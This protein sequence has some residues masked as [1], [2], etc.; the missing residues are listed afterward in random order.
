MHPLVIPDLTKHIRHA[1][2]GAVVLL[3]EA[4]ESLPLE[5]GVF[6]YEFHVFVLGMILQFG[7]QPVTARRFN[8][9]K[10]PADVV[11]DEGDYLGQDAIEKKIFFD[12]TV[13]GEF[14]QN[15]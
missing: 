2:K 6:R 5:L 3:K 7:V 1:L 9:I 12:S 10:E 4:L 13:M 11:V 14:L 8:D 15:E